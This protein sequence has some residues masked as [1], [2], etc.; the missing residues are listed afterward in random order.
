MS[1]YVKIKAIRL[2]IPQ[3]ISDKYDDLEEYFEQ[4]LGDSFNDCH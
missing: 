1:D 2:P 3:E 4:Q